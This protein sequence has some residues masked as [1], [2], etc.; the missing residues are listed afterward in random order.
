MTMFEFLVVGLLLAIL[1]V[2]GLVL[3]HVHDLYQVVLKKSQHC[4]FDAEQQ[5]FF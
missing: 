2:A 4:E 1:V 3:V 5:E